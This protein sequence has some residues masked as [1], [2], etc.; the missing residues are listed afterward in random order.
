ELDPGSR[1]PD[2]APA[3][4]IRQPVL[5]VPRR[6]ELIECAAG[7]IL[8]ISIAGRDVEL[9]DQPDRE[10]DWQRLAQLPV[11]RPRP[12]RIVRDRAGLNGH[13]DVVVESRRQL[14]DEAGADR[15]RGQ[16]GDS[17]ALR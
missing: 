1:V 5:V 15:G 9:P 2:V 8:R 17:A 10:S 12:Y 13:L 7:S 4:L 6:I 16:A 3:D 11:T 14:A